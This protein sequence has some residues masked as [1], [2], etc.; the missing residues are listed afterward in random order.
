MSIAGGEA[1][2][3][4]RGT[5]ATV[6]QL[7]DAMVDFSDYIDTDAL[8]SEYLESVDYLYKSGNEVVAIPTE[9]TANGMIYNKT[10][11]DGCWCDDPH[12]S[13]RCLDL[14]RVQGRPTE[15]CGQ[16]RCQVR[17]LSI[18]HLTAG[19]PSC[20]NSAAAWLTKTAATFPVL[21]A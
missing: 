5:E 9:V 20:M 1:P 6:S 18:T 8:Q 2:Q 12:R 21:R 10:A 11:F 14:G 15:S 19:P 17:R 3:C 13:R 7:H 4:L 16:W